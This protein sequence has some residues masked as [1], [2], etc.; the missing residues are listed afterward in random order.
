[1]SLQEKC[2]NYCY[3]NKKMFISERKVEDVLFNN[4][5]FILLYIF[6]DYSS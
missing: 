5:K 3:K 1:M 4:S 6:S 2:F